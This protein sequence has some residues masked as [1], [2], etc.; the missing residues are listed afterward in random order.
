MG[1]CVRNKSILTII[2][3]GTLVTV[4][5]M[6][7]Y[8]I[9]VRMNGAGEPTPPPTS[10]LQQNDQ[11]S[12]GKRQ[13]PLDNSPTLPPTNAKSM[14]KFNVGQTITPQYQQQ[15][16][17]KTVSLI[18]ARTV[19]NKKLGRAFSRRDKFSHKLLDR[20]YRLK[21]QERKHL[22]ARTRLVLE[23]EKQQQLNPFPERA[24]NIRL[25]KKLLRTFK[26][27]LKS[28][29][30]AHKSK[31]LRPSPMSS[32]STSPSSSD[33]DEHESAIGNAILSIAAEKLGSELAT[34]NGTARKRRA[35]Q[36][37]N[38]SLATLFAQ[39][40]P[41]QAEKDIDGALAV[42]KQIK[43][44]KLDLEDDPKP[45]ETAGTGPQLE[46]DAKE[47]KVE[48]ST[49][50]DANLELKVLE[51]TPPPASRASAKLEADDVEKEANTGAGAPPPPAK[52]EVKEK[53][54]PSCAGALAVETPAK[55]EVDEKKKT[56]G[57]GA[58]SVA[59][60][61]TST[62]DANEKRP[63]SV[64]AAVSSPTKSVSS[65]KED[66]IVDAAV[67]PSK[68]A[69]KH[70]L[71]SDDSPT[72]AKKAKVEYF[73]TP[74]VPPKSPKKVTPAVPPTSPKR[75]N[76]AAPL[77]YHEQVVHDM[78]NDPLGFDDLVY[79]SKGPMH[80]RNKFRSFRNRY[81]KPAP[82]FSPL[83]SGGIGKDLP[84]ETKATAVAALK[85]R[86]PLPPARNSGTSARNNAEKMLPPSRN[87]AEKLNLK[88][89]DSLSQQVLRKNYRDRMT[90]RVQESKAAASEE[91]KSPVLDN[92]TEKSKYSVNKEA[93][94]T[95]NKST[96]IEHAGLAIAGLTRSIPA[97]APPREGPKPKT[98]VSA[99][100][101]KHNAVRRVGFYK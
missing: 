100:R 64:A 26:R 20:H 56:A 83:M 3:I 40:H 36:R 69:K 84:E 57:A 79:D 7:I 21:H 71:D 74:A 47:G 45:T 67:S 4:A 13:L 37:S 25:L 22:T 51:K 18:F 70:P 55:P 93:R 68:N 34:V 89:E 14:A 27:H 65:D 66:K 82:N 10:G 76:P 41:E 95:K 77:K 39:D 24:K 59:S 48:V 58:S 72:K 90:Q 73:A 6:A 35:S 33:M 49:G 63:D 75:N 54:E 62:A 23:L 17:R 43:K 5:S 1:S 19:L 81:K 101:R 30:Y 78:L 60:P 94:Y 80:N 46:D 92:L 98:Y 99:A 8:K 38:A 53:E 32:I 97:E 16:Y 31:C 85:T 88:K 9:A 42:P 91:K 52:S 61:T 86:K 15:L 44:P 28:D 87:N 2:T 96:N 12:K 11:G 50:N 29:T